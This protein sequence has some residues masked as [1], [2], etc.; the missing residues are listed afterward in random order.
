MDGS[1]PA[2]PPSRRGDPERAFGG[3]L[4]T[5]PWPRR[6]LARA[7][8]SSP[9]CLEDA[10]G[11]GCTRRRATAR[12]NDA[13][14]GRRGFRRVVRG[15]ATRPG[16]CE[17]AGPHVRRG[18]RAGRGRARRAIDRTEGSSS[19][20]RRASSRTNRTRI[21][22]DPAPR[23]RSSMP[24]GSPR[25]GGERIP[26]STS[27]PIRPAIRARGPRGPRSISGSSAPSPPTPA[28][29]RSV[30]L[31]PVSGLASVAGH[32]NHPPGSPAAVAAPT[33][34]PRIWAR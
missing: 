21:P 34:L 14:A 3:A 13:G 20:A 31:L 6:A 11:R 28:G 15:A 23:A 24:R 16:A 4:V 32:P 12:P 1:L 5:S 17:P 18:T 33:T 22:S 25:R 2:T 19:T 29:S 27:P 30:S 9:R 10:G 8:S 26:G 7:P